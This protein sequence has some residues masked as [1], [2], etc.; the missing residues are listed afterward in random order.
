MR[1]E[2]KLSF[3]CRLLLC[4]LA[5]CADNQKSDDDYLLE[6]VL[7]LVQTSP[8]RFF[9]SSEL[10]EKLFLS[11]RTLRNRFLRCYGKTPCRYQMEIKL[12]TACGYLKNN[13]DMPLREI[14]SNLGFYDEFHFSKRFKEIY[15]ISPKEYR[16]R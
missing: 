5:E 10:A 12:Q 7:H 8:E 1:K 11:E 14:A 2:E 16:R 4:E 6:Q 3:L 13:P 15:R 9:R